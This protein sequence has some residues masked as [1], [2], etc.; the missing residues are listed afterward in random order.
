MQ[1]TVEANRFRIG[2][3]LD[4]LS[5]TRNCSPHTYAAYSGT[6]D[7][8]VAHLDATPLGEASV[9]DL[10]A[11]VERP[12]QRRSPNHVRGQVVVGSAATRRRD[13]TVLRSMY[14]FLRERG[15]VES[16]RSSLL[17]VPLLNNR[18]PRPVDDDVWRAVWG[19]DVL[20]DADRV[21][22][23][24]GFFCG[25]RRAEITNLN[26]SQVDCV[27]GQLVGFVRK[28]GGEAVFPY[29]SAVRLFA[30]RLP[31]LVGDP[32]AFLGAVERRVDARSGDL[33]MGWGSS[34]PNRSG[35]RGG[36]VRGPDWASHAMNRQVRRV[37]VRCGL[38]GGVLTPHALR[39]S[40]V[41]NLLR[42]DVPL[43]VVA[44]LAGHRDVST[45]MRYAAIAVDPLADL[46]AA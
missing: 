12:R 20:S 15:L 6:L 37:L 45:T 18:N 22:F 33:V 23:G 21:M 35:G 42:A 29:R 34:T 4:W 24:L 25:L 46:L 38:D 30:E 44:S 39:H 3:Y 27:Q 36:A 40:F 2:A 7:K 17:R 26:A 1:S 43:H 9:M 10:E 19:S 28:G 13:I 5:G 14:R 11:F 8:L 41:T 16:D 32:Q 31:R